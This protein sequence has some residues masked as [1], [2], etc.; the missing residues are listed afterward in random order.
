VYP[1]SI[2][3]KWNIDLYHASVDKSNHFSIAALSMLVNT[4]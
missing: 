1:A 4:L 2:L 3:A